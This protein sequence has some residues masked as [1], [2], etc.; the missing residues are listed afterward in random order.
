MSETITIKITFMDGQSLNTQFTP[1]DLV[2]WQR[3]SKLDKLLANPVLP[4]VIDGNAMFFPMNNIRSIQ[5]T[6]A[7]K[8]LPPHIIRTESVPT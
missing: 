8:A 5:V 4:I 2:E 1:P 6:P 3:G 7:P